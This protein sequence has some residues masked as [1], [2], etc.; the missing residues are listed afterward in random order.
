ML[1]EDGESEF[2]NPEEVRRDSVM[3]KEND[4]S[5]NAKQG[6][7]KVSILQYYKQEKNFL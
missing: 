4:L 5:T 7:V 1:S 2:A 3:V 6:F